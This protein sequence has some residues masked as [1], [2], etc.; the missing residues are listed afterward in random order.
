[1]LDYDLHSNYSLTL[2][3]KNFLKKGLSGIINPDTK[4][5]MISILQ[6]FSHTI[7]LTDYLL[8]YSYKKHAN[9]KKKELKVLNAY[10]E[11]L[12]ELWDYNKLVKIKK[13]SN[14]LNQIENRFNNLEQQDSHE[15]LMYFLEALHKSMSY[16]IEVE[17]SGTVKNEYDSI[18]KQSI[19]DWTSFYEKE[20]SFISENFHGLYHNKLICDNCNKEFS[21][22]EPFQTLSLQVSDSLNESLN[23]TLKFTENLSSWKCESCNKMGCSK[24]TSIFDFPDILIVTLKNFDNNN[25]KITNDIFF[26]DS[27]LDLTKYLST[28]K[29]DNNNYVYSLHAVN[30]HIGSSTNGHYYSVCKNLDGNWYQLDDGN[31]SKFTGQLHKNAYIL[32]FHRKK[33]IKN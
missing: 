32:F 14:I 13:F 2:K 19:I 22:F 1:M 15:F 9:I 20:Y 3:K 21:K 28:H 11:L 29:N 27:D 10:I 7:L 6:C 4:C 26:D 16:E 31:V 17:I 30:C 5:Y 8:S 12:S 24:S 25:K 18:M 23:N 33:I